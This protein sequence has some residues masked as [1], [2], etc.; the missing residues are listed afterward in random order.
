[1]PSTRGALTS[2]CWIVFAFFA[3]SASGMAGDMDVPLL[4]LVGFVALAVLWT[5]A[6]KRWHVATPAGISPPLA[7]S[8]ARDLNRMDSD[9]G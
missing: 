8:D 5:V 1:M 6:A 2:A 9:K 7:A 4:V 3:L